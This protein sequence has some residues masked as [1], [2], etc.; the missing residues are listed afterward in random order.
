MNRGVCANCA[1]SN[2]VPAYAPA[3]TVAGRMAEL[4]G[5]VLELKWLIAAEQPI[6]GNCADAVEW[7][8]AKSVAPVNCAALAAM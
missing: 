1:E 8:I 5:A 2:I 7:L 3:E 4:R 6:E